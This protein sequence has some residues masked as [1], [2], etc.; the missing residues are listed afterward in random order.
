[1]EL[2][3]YSTADIWIRLACLDEISGNGEVVVLDCN[4]KRC[5]VPSAR[6]LAL[7]ERI[8]VEHGGALDNKLELH[9]VSGLARRKEVQGRRGRGKGHRR[10]DETQSADDVLTSFCRR[11]CWLMGDAGEQLDEIEALSAIYDTATFIPTEH[12]GQTRISLPR[13][14]LSSS[15]LLLTIHR[16]STARGA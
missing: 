9:E 14:L 1:M 16:R 7:A 4:E 2:V 8:R 10:V 5:L 3:D 11:R 12:S 6:L 15:S 13:Q